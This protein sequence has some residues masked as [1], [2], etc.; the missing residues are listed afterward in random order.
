LQI[1]KKLEKMKKWIFIAFSCMVLVFC[2]ISF[3]SAVPVYQMAPELPDA[4]QYI[5]DALAQNKLVFVGEYHT[6]LNEELFMA[7]NMQA[8]YNAGLRY[9]F[10]EDNED[11]EPLQAP[12]LIYPPWRNDVGGRTIGG[13]YEGDVVD[14]AIQ[15]INDAVPESE[16]IR[17]IPAE[18]GYNPTLEEGNDLNKRDQQAFKNISTFMEK[19]P[20]NKKAMIFYGGDHGI[21]KPIPGERIGGSGGGEPFLWT[22][23]GAY[24]KEQYGDNFISMVPLSAKD[25]MHYFSLDIPELRDSGSKPKIV[26]SNSKY[27]VVNNDRIR[28]S[29]SQYDAVLLDRE[30]LYGFG[31]NYNPT[32]EYLVAMYN[33]LRNLENSIDTWKDDVATFRFQEQGQYLQLIYCLK[34]WLGDSFDYRLW[35]TKKSLR[36]ALDAL[37]ISNIQE[38]TLTFNAQ[39]TQNTQK[40]REYI[41]IMLMSGVMPLVLENPSE[42]LFQE[43]FQWIVDHMK[44]AIAI[45][46]QDLWPYYWLAYSE[47][48]LGDYDV[49]IA[50]W[51]YIIAQP[52]SYCLETLPMVYQ[53]LS[54][55]YAATGDQA[56]SDEYRKTGE[57]LLNEHHL[58]VTNLNDVR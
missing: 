3:T 37:N 33:A 50:H 40:M 23:M 6:Q 18:A 17:F 48:E 51:E 21:I 58:I 31:V 13:K 2:R 53:K 49:A 20:P 16:R 1:L 35:D 44:E 9:I 22:P 45:F 32:Y 30:S 4:K 5:L 55:C 14:R 19:L 42:E 57:S 26:L 38:I 12:L 11:Y 43:L 34:L 8:F 10:V 52:L 15:T 47:T 25:E 29:L 36:E 28:Q 24:L 39:D 46:P 54:V 56:K 27:D 7:E 41:K